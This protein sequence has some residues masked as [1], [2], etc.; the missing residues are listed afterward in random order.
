M[1]PGTKLRFNVRVCGWPEHRIAQRVCW[2][3]RPRPAPFCGRSRTPCPGPPFWCMRC[4][5][6]AVL[7]IV[8][9]SCGRSGGPPSPAP[10][11]SEP[12]GEPPAT[13]EPQPTPEPVPQRPD[14][15][16][17]GPS[18]C[19]VANDLPLVTANAGCPPTR[20]LG[21]PQT[22][23]F[24]R[25][26]TSAC[27]DE[28]AVDGDGTVL[29][30]A[31]ESLGGGG[32][33][34][35]HLEPFR[36]DG[37]AV[38]PESGNHELLVPGASGFL[39]YVSPS[40]L[41]W[42]DSAWAGWREGTLG[43]PVSLS[44]SMGWPAYYAGLVAVAPDGAGGLLVALAGA[45]AK[46]DAEIDVARVAPGPVI[47][48]QPFAALTIPAPAPDWATDR[49][50]DALRRAVGKAAVGADGAGRILLV[51]NG[52]AACGAGTFAGRW[53]G[54]D[55]KALGPV[56]RAA[57]V[58]QLS[59]EPT[60]ANRDTRLFRLHDGSLVL[61]VADGRFVRRFEGGVPAG[62]PAPAWLDGRT[63]EDLAPVPLAGVIAAERPADSEGRARV[64]LVAPGGEVC[65]SFTL[66]AQALD[67]ATRSL[68]G[69]LAPAIGVDGSIVALD[70]VEQIPGQSN[71]TCAYRV[72]RAALR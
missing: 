9:L 34:V 43:W 70:R 13:P 3:R 50:A 32:Y 47:S 45:D 54:P 10:P 52:T 11:P 65:A 63:G 53:F 62:G 69:T 38:P 12:P 30:H 64:D 37:S 42:I 66:P 60:R 19:A 59:T 29:F 33:W 14:G 6:P 49:Y 16:G 28:I 26:F 22:L 1:Q 56:F 8:A 46:G 20:P 40:D 48:V 58:E 72:W 68:G 18:G 5:G 41:A 31:K 24:T 44:S 23:S 55:G 36:P 71:Y 4:S 17:S 15:P 61:R 67:D 7:L 39:S 21:A 2:R 51:W 35:S 57:T 25:H 27:A